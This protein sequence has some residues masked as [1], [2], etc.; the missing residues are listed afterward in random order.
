MS[1]L[2]AQGIDAASGSACTTE[3][4]KSS[5]VLEAIGVDPVLARGA[6]TLT[7]GATNA[8]SDP[9]RVG[10]ILPIIVNRLRQLSPLGSD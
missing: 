1:S 10:E 2:D 7:F 6:L 8:E 5:H 9:D 3:V 4:R